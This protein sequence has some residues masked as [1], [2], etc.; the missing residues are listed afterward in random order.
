MRRLFKSI[1][2]Q[3]MSDLIRKRHN[4]SLLLYH[5][6]FVAKYRRLVI[7]S[8]VELILKNV[9]K[10]ISKRYEIIERSLQSLNKIIKTTKINTGKHKIY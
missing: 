9:C 1:M 8:E 3:I 6:V 7:N 2:N 5:F 4:V 10:E